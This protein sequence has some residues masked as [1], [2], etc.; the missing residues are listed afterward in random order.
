M[1]TAQ[2]LLSLTLGSGKVKKGQV[3][4]LT[5]RQGAACGLYTV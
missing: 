1:A 4:R 3:A 5:R 2:P